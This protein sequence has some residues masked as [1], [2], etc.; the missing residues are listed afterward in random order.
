MARRPKLIIE[1]L[2]GPADGER[3]AVGGELPAELVKLRGR[4]APKIPVMPHYL[5]ELARDRRSIRWG[6]AL[7][8]LDP[9]PGKPIKLDPHQAAKIGADRA[10][11][12]WYRFRPRQTA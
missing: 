3:Y 12:R 9:A 10:R 7:Y 5:D 4:G 8:V 11:R 6:L 2:G 1:F